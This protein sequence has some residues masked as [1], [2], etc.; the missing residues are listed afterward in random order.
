MTKWQEICNKT[1]LA[2]R[3]RAG[4]AEEPQTTIVSKGKV[5]ETQAPGRR[6]L[7]RGQIFSYR[8]QKEKLSRYALRTLFSHAAINAY[9][10]LLVCVFIYSVMTAMKPR[11]ET[12]PK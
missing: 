3:L 2:P 4:K 9:I 11:E 8:Y 12:E 10:H 6:I 5:V 7:H 1:Q